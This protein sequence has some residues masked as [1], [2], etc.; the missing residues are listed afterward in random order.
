MNIGILIIIIALL[1]YLSN[2]LNWKYLNNFAIRFLYYIGTFIHELSHI[3]L[4][5]LTGAKIS[6][7]SI[8]SR[9]PKIIHSKSRIP[10]IGQALISLAPIIGGMAFLYAI[11]RFCLS[12]YFTVPSNFKDFLTIFSGIGILDWQLWVMILLS[13]NMG[14]MI[15]P[16]LQDLKHIW[17]VLIL[18]LFVKWPVLINISLLA[19]FLILLNILI[20]GILIVILSIVRKIRGK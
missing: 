1:G 10:I 20:Q 13:F 18:L 9:Q 16:S 3:I 11:N 5:I 19:I 7:I 8:F 12:N 4:C 14:A 6:K 2:Y 15:G 17:F